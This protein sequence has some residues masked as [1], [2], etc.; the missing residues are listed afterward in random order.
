MDRLFPLTVKQ[1]LWTILYKKS[2]CV[3]ANY[4]LIMYSLIG[5]VI[6][7]IYLNDNGTRHPATIGIFSAIQF[8]WKFV[9]NKKYLSICILYHSCYLSPTS[10]NFGFFFKIPQIWVQKGIFRKHYHFIFILHQILFFIFRKNQLFRLKRKQVSYIFE[11]PHCFIRILLEICHNFVIQS[12]NVSNFVQLCNWQVKV[13][14]HAL[15]GGFF[16][17]FKYGRKMM[18]EIACYTFSRS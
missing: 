9:L 5:C 10:A 16:S 18:Q 14:R 13:K 15:S 4:L 3:L 11:K 2:A 8:S 6:P 17:I 7:L 12:Q 1:D